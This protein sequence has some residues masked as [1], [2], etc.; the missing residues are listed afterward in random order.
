MKLSACFLSLAVL[1]F[2]LPASGAILL[3]TTGTID[4]TDPTLERRLTRT[5]LPSD[6]SWEKDFPGYTGGVGPRLYDLWSF[7][8]AATDPRYL[9]ISIDDPSG[10]VF[11]SAHFGAFNPADLSVG[12]AGDLGATG[13][14]FGFPGFY[15]IHVP[16]AGQ[17]FLLVNRTDIGATLPSYNYGI[18]VES[19]YTPNFDEIPEP[20]T[21]GLSAAGLVGLFVLRHKRS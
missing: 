7:T 15:Q 18:I 2:G 16:A 1:T 19:F 13:N 3:D 10:L 20:A 9:Q 11:S 8:F 14:P 17:L 6:W 4:D 12:Y 21:I 5:G